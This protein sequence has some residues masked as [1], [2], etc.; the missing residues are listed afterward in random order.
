MRVNLANGIQVIAT[1][2]AALDEVARESIPDPARIFPSQRVK[3]ATGCVHR[4]GCLSD[5]NLP[6]ASHVE[7]FSR[8]H[9]GNQI[10]MHKV[11]RLHDVV[12][13]RVHP[14][15]QRRFEGLTERIPKCPGGCTV[16]CFCPKT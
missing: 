5:G 7:R 11:G 9:W 10:R 3:L 4:F 1:H 8:R 14:L 15:C 16:A 2:S 6:D 12:E 13:E